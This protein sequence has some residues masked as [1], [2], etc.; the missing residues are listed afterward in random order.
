MER[1]LEAE[2][3]ALEEPDEL[4][5]GV[6]PD[7]RR[8]LAG[9]AGTRPEPGGLYASGDRI[10]AR[11]LD[12][13]GAVREAVRGNC[14]AGEP[15]GDDVA[16]HGVDRHLAAGPHR[17][18]EGSEDRG[19]VRLVTVAERAEQAEC[20]VEAR[21]AE[22]CTEVVPQVTQP[23]GCEITSPPLGLREQVSRLVHAEDASAQSRQGQ[24]DPSVA[25]A[26][27]EHPN[28]LGEP[29]DAPQGRGLLVATFR[30][31]GPDAKVLLIEE[32]LPPCGAGHGPA[33]EAVSS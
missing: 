17:A 22:R 1:G 4:G 11:L 25:A 23:L 15:G 12:Q 18:S 19:V 29:E 6:H 2:A 32:L 27:V 3:G 7:G 10:E 28:A 8:L 21:L 33:A 16:V 13:Q 30:D 5:D 20:G 26:G 14:F 31:G 24:A 9:A